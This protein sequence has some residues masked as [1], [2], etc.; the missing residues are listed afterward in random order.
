MLKFIN[1]DT[2]IRTE[3]PPYMVI[4]YIGVDDKK[5]ILYEQQDITLDILFD[6]IQAGLIEKV[7][8]ER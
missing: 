1:E 7:E 6:L 2:K 8:E 3:K 5:I 4:K